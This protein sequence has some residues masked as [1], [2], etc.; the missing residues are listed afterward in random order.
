MTYDE[1]SH[2]W[3]MHLRANSTQYEDQSRRREIY[4]KVV[5]NMK[6]GCSTMSCLKVPPLNYIL[7]CGGIHT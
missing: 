2:R 3:R 5:H 6:V 4:Q 7:D 1:L